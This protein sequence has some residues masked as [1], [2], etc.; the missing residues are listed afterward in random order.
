MRTPIPLSR[1]ESRWNC[2]TAYARYIDNSHSHT[3]PV[4]SLRPNDLGV[5]DMYGNVWE[6]CQDRFKQNG[7]E[8]LE[9]RAKLSNPIQTVC[10]P[11]A[12]YN[13]RPDGLN[14]PHPGDAKMSEHGYNFG[15]R[16]VRTYP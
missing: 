7:Q 4:G 1:S 14:A 6:W 11:A 13:D 12:R 5:F 10:W 9:A 16:P 15:F 2:W 8:R 3:W